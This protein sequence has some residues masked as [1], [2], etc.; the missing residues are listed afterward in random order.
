MHG[1]HKSLAAAPLLVLLYSEMCMCVDVREVW[2]SEVGRRTLW[3]WLCVPTLRKGLTYNDI[4]PYLFLYVLFSLYWCISSLYEVIWIS[5]FTKPLLFSYQ[6][7][8]AQLSLSPPAFIY[9]S[10]TP[11]MPCGCHH[12]HVETKR[13]V[14]FPLPGDLPVFHFSMSSIKR[15][16][17]IIFKYLYGLLSITRFLCWWDDIWV[18]SFLILFYWESPPTW[19][20]VR[21]SAT[22]LILMSGLILLKRGWY[23]HL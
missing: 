2:M 19:R 4:A 14:T 15:E 3:T 18:S 5:A 8:P 23:L 9:H 16:F 17:C 1:F 20:P 13:A 7:A 12:T 22:C 6:N 10:T 11:F 21:Y